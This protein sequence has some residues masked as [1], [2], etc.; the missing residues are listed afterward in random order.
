MA[1]SLAAFL[2]KEIW[3][4]FVY[5]ASSD[6]PSCFFLDVLA[7]DLFPL[8]S[9]SV[10]GGTPCQSPGKIIP[11]RSTFASRPGRS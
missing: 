9:I 1:D 7:K 8:V 3:N 10:S 5:A 4:N 2:S 6:V 11:V